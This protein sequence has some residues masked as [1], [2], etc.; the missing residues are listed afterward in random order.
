MKK[1]NAQ[2]SLPNKS[3]VLTEFLKGLLAKGPVGV[4]EIEDMAR[5][6]GHLGKRKSITH[7]KPFQAAKKALGVRSIRAGFATAGRWCWHLPRDSTTTK[8]N[9]VDASEMGSRIPPA[10]VEGIARLK[11]HSRP[12]DVS[13]HRWDRFL[14]DCHGFIRT[15]WPVRAARLGW[16]PLALFGCSLRGTLLHPGSAGLVWTLAGGKLIELHREWAVIETANGSRRVFERR[17]LKA[18][19]L[20]LPWEEGSA[21]TR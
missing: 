19:K 8:A 3:Q 7:S 18:A 20:V 6:A 11:D 21:V 13:P 10:W 16:N 17:R 9:S 14:A 1:A 12:G 15:E 2:N 4:P 5:A